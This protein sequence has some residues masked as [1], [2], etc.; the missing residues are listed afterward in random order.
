[1]MYAGDTVRLK[2]HFK[3][4]VGESINPQNVTLT[5][6]DSKKE[7]IEQFTLDDTNQQDE[8]VFFYDYVPNNSDGYIFEFAGTYNDNPILVRDS[9]QVKFN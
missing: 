8:G 5:I 1:M 7:Q 2:V 9:V 3:S 4:F 6:Y